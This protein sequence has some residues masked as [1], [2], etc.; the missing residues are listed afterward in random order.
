MWLYDKTV[1]PPAPFLDALLRSPVEAT[2]A[3]T[4]PAKLDTAADNHSH[5]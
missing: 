3:L 4:V 5:S 2:L 1:S